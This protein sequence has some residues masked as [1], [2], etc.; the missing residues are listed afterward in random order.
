MRALFVTTRSLAESLRPTLAEEGVVV[1]VAGRGGPPDAEGGAEGYDVLILDRD[2]LGGGCA[3][4]LRW[5]R[6]GLKAH[7]VVVFPQECD[8]RERAD[9]LDAGADAFLLQ[10]LCAQE[11]LAHFRALK[12]RQGQDPSP[13]RRVHDLEINTA[14]REVR[15][16]GVPIPLTPREFD[17]LGL[18]VSSQG[19][20]VSRTAIRHHLY[21]DHDEKA[22]NVIDVYIR[23]LRNKID[24]GLGKPLILTRWGQG[25][26][27]RGQDD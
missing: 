21:P 20:V 27:L 14:S 9:A 19:R 2:R 13:V 8:S 12:R 3:C 5:R 26:L 4:L 16:A 22:S 25:Y 18:L 6:A 7:V 1:E 23:Y 17:L 15:R 11:L 10:P 24:R